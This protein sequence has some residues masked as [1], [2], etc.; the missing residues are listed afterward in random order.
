MATQNTR[1]RLIAAATREFAEHGVE[2]AS[3]LEITRQAGQRN[4]GAVHYHFGSRMGMLVAVLEQ[5]VD[6]LA[7]REEEIR[8]QAEE[9]PGDLSAAVEALVRP[10]AEL[11]ETGWEGRCY[12]M[13]VGQLVQ[14]GPFPDELRDVVARSGGYAVYDVIRSRMPEMSEALHNERVSLM[15]AFVM[16]SIAVRARTVERGGEIHL[17]VEQFVPNLVQMATA[18]LC[19]PL[20]E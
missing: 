9:R 20:P 15:A 16:W 12:V 2:N 18:M 10:A 11:A 17:P 7:P 13:I 6:F 8:R 19:A 4:R 14:E 5:F 3:L 1:A